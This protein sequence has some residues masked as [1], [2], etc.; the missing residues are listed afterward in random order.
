M[1]N[2][3][4]LSTDELYKQHRERHAEVVR[5]RAE[6]R[7]LDEVIA[8]KEVAAIVPTLGIPAQG[9]GFRIGEN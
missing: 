6:M 1:D 9:I 5:L 4:A 2:L 7:E 3:T 8:A